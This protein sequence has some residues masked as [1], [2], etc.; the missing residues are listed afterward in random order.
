MAGCVGLST[1]LLPLSK[2]EAVDGWGAAAQALGVYAVYK[3]SLVSILAL[4]ND[5][6]AQ[7]QS[8]AQD[9][10][11]NGLDPNPNDVRVVDAVMQQLVLHGDYVL[12]NN[13]LPF[14]WAV[15][16]SKD[17]NA[18]CYPTNYISVNKALVRGLNLEPDELAAVLAHEM[19]HGLEQHSA[20]NYAKAVA[21]YMG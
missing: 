12:K 10:R 6:N 1:A 17:F 20:S 3:S 8:R 4:G 16:D 14:I 5:A 19:T 13:S 2:A 11:Q 18:A 15:N 7:V 9:I 21:Q